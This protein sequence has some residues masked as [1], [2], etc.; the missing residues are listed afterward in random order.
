MEGCILVR[1]REVSID[2]MERLMN[3]EMIGIILWLEMQ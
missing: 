2:Y 1:R 3:E